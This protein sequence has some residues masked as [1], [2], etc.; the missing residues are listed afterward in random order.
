MKPITVDRRDFTIKA[1]K[2]RRSGIVPGNVFG[3]PFSEPVSIQ[4]EEAV[5]NRLFRNKREGSKLKL[6]LEGQL[7]SVQIKE[8]VVNTL[9]HEILHMS[10]QALKDDQKVNS[11][12]HIL[13]Q[14]AEK[15]TDS[16]EKMVMEIP[17]ASLPEDMIDTITIDA[18]GMAS[19]SVVTVGDIPELK[20]ERIELQIAE[21]EIVF[22][23][24]DKKRGS[25]PDEKP[26]A[27]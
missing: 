8:K 21:D 27:E 9:N 16:L 26:D 23:L 24:N 10:F 25:A 6:D 18:E 5:A 15:V 20:S 3:G 4:M 1:K 22:R 13:L 2:L 7:I 12:I 19:G 17:Y 11:V 14:N